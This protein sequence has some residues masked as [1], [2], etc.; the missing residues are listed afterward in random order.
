MENKSNL[1]TINGFSDVLKNYNKSI[2]QLLQSKYGISVEEFYVTCVNAVKKTPKLLQ[3]DPKSLF[4]AILLSA[5]CGLR[6][7]TPEG[8]AYILPYRGEAKFQIG[9]KG[10]IEMMYR[11]PRVKSISAEA[12]FEND[13]F[14]YGYGLNPFLTHKPFRGGDRGILV[15]VYAVCKLQDADPIFTVVEKS[16]LDKVKSFSQSAMGDNAQFSPYNNGTDVHNFM[17]KKVAIKKISKL[18]P[19]SS[20]TEISKAID[21]DSRFEGGARVKAEILNNSNEIVEPILIDGKNSVSLENTFDS[22]E[23]ADTIE[24]AFDT[25]IE[26]PIQI[27]KPIEIEKIVVSKEVP[28]VVENDEEE[29]NEE[30]I[31]F[32]KFSDEMSSEEDTTLF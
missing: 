30:S 20:A 29:E 27:E 24:N 12:V 25:P 7:N 18:I 14:D 11:N 19:K 10:L 31:D 2:A 1:S 4:G 28:S 5:E 8:H 13:E 26:E 15:C 21:Y 17:E 16:D 3:C 9:Y 23:D 22:I 6:P 32:S